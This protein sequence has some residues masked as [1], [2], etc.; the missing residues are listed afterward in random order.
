MDLGRKVERVVEVKS[1]F[2]MYDTNE[3][4]RYKII[5]DT[6]DLILVASVETAGERE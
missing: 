2:K 4:L 6:T 1:A 5:P 3:K